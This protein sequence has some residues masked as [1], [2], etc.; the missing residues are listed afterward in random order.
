MENETDSVFFVYDYSLDD[1]AV[2][3]TYTDAIEKFRHMIDDAERNKDCDRHFMFGRIY[4]AYHS[5]NQEL[6]K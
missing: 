2:I 3:G 1:F 4:A 5:L 6:P